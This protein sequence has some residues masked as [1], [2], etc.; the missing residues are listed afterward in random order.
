[1]SASDPSADLGRLTAL[2]TK[3]ILEST[4]RKV[5]PRPADRLI[6]GGLLDSLSMVNLVIALQSEFAVQ[7]E[8]ADLNEE[9]FGSIEAIARMLGRPR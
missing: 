4:G 9:N 2:V 3:V 7:L 8:V 6:E 5:T 1:M